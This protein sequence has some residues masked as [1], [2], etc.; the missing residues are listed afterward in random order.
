MAAGI[1]L[2]VAIAILLAANMSE[3]REA[4]RNSDSGNAENLYSDDVVQLAY[5][6]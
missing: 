6:K 5:V 1:K 4:G 2:I 3:A